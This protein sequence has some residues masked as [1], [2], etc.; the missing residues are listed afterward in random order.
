MEVKE[1]R[2]ESKPVLLYVITSA[3][4]H[5]AQKYVYDMAR[6]AWGRGDYDV[7][8]AVG[9]HGDLVERLTAVGIPTCTLGL[10][11][12][13]DLTS[14]VRACIELAKLLRDIKPSVLHLNSSKIGFT[15]AVL[16]RF[17]RVPRIV[18]TAHGW[19]F[20]VASTRSA[21]KVYTAMM[22]A[23]VRA[24]HLTIAVSGQIKAAWDGTGLLEKITVIH[25]GIEIPSLM[26]RE[27]A[28]A[29]LA[30]SRV[31]GIS[32]VVSIGELHHRKGFDT[33]IQAMALLGRADVHYHVIGDGNERPE[34]E[35]LIERLGLKGRV[36]LHGARADAASY[37]AAADL[38]L[39]PS[40][41][42]PFGY[43]ALEA[44]SARVPLVATR[45]GGLPEIIEDHVSGLLAEP[46]GPES[47]AKALQRMLGADDA[48]R[49]RICSA[50]RSRIE[51]EFSLERMCSRTYES[52]W[53]VQ[54]C[55][56]RGEAG[57]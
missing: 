19:P 51:E 3:S 34:L 5:G 12:E 44:A 45:V 25:N 30:F 10:K 15:G 49:A 57:C 11:R 7:R 33:A 36:Y 54:R 53:S 47:L 16:G 38:F 48:F 20:E 13:V 8:V 50:A 56:P 31:S 2:V 55:R 4:R 46:D 41:V 43:V 52:Y 9:H 42:E 32:H 28:R 21:R 27:A 14:D 17:L 40:R 24:S 26:A 23:T 29:S 22:Y 37:L 1:A 39:V 6:Y 18:F 35:R